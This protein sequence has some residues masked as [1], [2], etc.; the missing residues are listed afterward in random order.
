MRILMIAPEPFFQPRGT[1]F[2]EY[3]RARAFTELG[4]Q[5]DMVT[6]SIGSDVSIP[7]LRI[8]RAARVPGVRSVRIGPSLAKIPLDVVLF[9]SAIRRLLTRRYDLL[10]CHEE[11]GLMGVVLSRVFGLP[12]VYDMH[13]SLPEQLSNFRFS[14]SRLLRWL[15]DVGERWCIRGSDAVIVICPYLK[16]VVGRVDPDRPSFLIENSP[17][18]E[19]GEPAGAAE[20]S[21]L[22]RSLGLDNAK[23]I[24]YTGTFEAYQGFELLMDAIQKVVQQE[25]QAHL[26]MV[27]GHPEQVRD[28]E[29]LARNKGLEGKVTFT[30]QRP[31]SE[32]TL[33]L[34]V[35]D[36][37][38]SPRSRG[39]NTPL[40]IYS[41]LRA[42]K[43]IVATRLLTHTQVLNDD[44]AALT[45]PQPEA[46]AE[47]MVALIREPERARNLGQNARR[48]S[49]ESYSYERYVENTRRLF[50]FF[51]R[52][53]QEGAVSRA[54]IE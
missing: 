19:S 33:Y 46:F 17:L 37:L 5:V 4:H 22:R 20:V 44:V 12:T 32:M 14:R 49:E 39:T 10:D 29:Q 26:L 34:S 43:P 27:G 31:P 53:S 40:K 28:A 7:G 11:A 8:Y 36:I 2:S 52:S 47:A 13:S 24:L 15:F 51:S 18:A 6:Y 48:L 45:E 41:Y 9:F 16:D 38:V 42:G 23:I 3:Y 35:G 30:G 54:S 25:P 50:E 21:N 1:P